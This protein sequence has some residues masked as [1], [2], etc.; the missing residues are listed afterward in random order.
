MYFKVQMKGEKTSKRKIKNIRG[1]LK[2]RM[3]HRT[4]TYSRYFMVICPICSL[5]GAQTRTVL[6]V[7]DVLPLLLGWVEL[8][9]LPF[10]LNILSFG[11]DVPEGGPEAESSANFSL[12]FSAWISSWAGQPQTEYPPQVGCFLHTAPQF[13]GTQKLNFTKIWA[14]KPGMHLD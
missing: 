2:K 1:M 5:F 14:L 12:L 8:V 11:Q 13:C 6:C 4:E 9:L 7:W 10:S 3:I